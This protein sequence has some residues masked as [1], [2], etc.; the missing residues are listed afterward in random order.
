MCQNSFPLVRA[1]APDRLS[2]NSCPKFGRRWQQS[3]TNHKVHNI[4]WHAARKRLTPRKNRLR[5]PAI[6]SQFRRLLPSQSRNLI[7]RAILNIQNIKDSI[8]R[9]RLGNKPDRQV[10]ACIRRWARKP[11]RRLAIRA[12]RNRWTMSIWAIL[13]S[14]ATRS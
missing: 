2:R 8:I 6:Q 13:K 9:K 5:R 12:N 10:W 3:R 14:R 1:T 7:L 4:H 11:F